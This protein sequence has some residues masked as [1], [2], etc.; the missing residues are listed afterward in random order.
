MGIPF[1]DLKAQYRRIQD[2]V[3]SG[4]DAVL[5]H[6]AY[7]M[8]PE[9]RD[10]ESTLA[11]F[12][13]VK[14]AVGCASG[15]DALTMALL[16]LGVG[17]GDAVFTTPFTFMAT[18]ETVALL[19]ATPVFVD[20]DPVTYNIDPA[21]L[22]RKISKV[23]DEQKLT[24][25]GVIAVDIFGVPADYDR[26]EPMAKNNGLFLIVDA[27]QSFGATYK[28]RPVCSFGDVACT[29]FFPAKPLGCYGD[30][31]MVFT[32]DDTLNELLLS[33]RVH[34]QGKDKYDNERLGITGRLDSMQAA[35]LKAKFTIF[36]EEIELRNKVADRYARELAAV[37]DLVAPSVPDDCVGV[38]A[39]YCVMARDSRHRAELQAK[40]QAEGIPSPI[41]YPIPLH[42]QTAYASLGYQKGDL[43]VS[44]NV[45]ERIFALPM[46]PYLSTEHQDLVVSTLAKED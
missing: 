29:S 18:A 1:I 9:I 32:D 15:T 39:Q 31:G 5:E 7:I 44:E 22:R 27:A 41:Y 4:I 36:P 30:G 25:R 13:S 14:H 17:P 16:S 26:I 46:Y 43:P 28:G 34:G 21:D 6:G 45:A 12:C 35:V 37:P 19:G 33:V 23:H 40:L 24:P 20:I 10:I 38:W 2:E 42:L 11:E 8:G 3:K